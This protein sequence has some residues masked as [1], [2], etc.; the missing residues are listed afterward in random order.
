MQF[1]HPSPFIKLPSSHNSAP[2]KTPSPHYV[3]FFDTGSAKYPILQFDA[4]TQFVAY[5]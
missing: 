5:K 2:Y 3:H 4:N 1:V